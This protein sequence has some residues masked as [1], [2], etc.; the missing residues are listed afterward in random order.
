M[1]MGPRLA[2]MEV[3]KDK[4]AL[5]RKVGSERL[6]LDPRMRPR[7]PAKPSV[8]EWLERMEGR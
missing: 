4:A 8:S 1:A 6:E 7:R 3:C 5:H 2:E